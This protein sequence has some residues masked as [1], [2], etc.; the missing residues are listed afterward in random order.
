MTTDVRGDPFAID[1]PWLTNALEQAGVARGARVLG[2]ERVQ[3]V[4]TGQMGRNARFSLA[5]DE[6]AGRPATVVCKF[7]TDDA[8]ARATGFDNGTYLKEFVFYTE[9]R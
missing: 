8:T 9:L 4:G 6:P 5:W 2:V 3:F 7:P 1:A